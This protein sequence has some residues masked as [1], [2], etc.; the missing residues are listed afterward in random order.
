MEEGDNGA[1]HLAGAE[2]ERVW[3]ARHEGV[4]DVGAVRVENALESANTQCTHGV[5]RRTQGCENQRAKGFNHGGMRHDMQQA[6]EA[7]KLGRGLLWRR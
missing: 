6:A 1:D 3:E 7:G 4:E 5:V 2:V